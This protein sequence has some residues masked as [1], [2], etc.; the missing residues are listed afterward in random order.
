MWFGYLSSVSWA[1]AKGGVPDRSNGE[2]ALGQTS[3]QGGG[4]TSP[5]WPRN[6]W[7]SPNQS[8]QM[9]PGKGMRGARCWIKE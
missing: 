8:K 2:E 1:P 5:I 4:S 7:G 6:T 3:A 9:L